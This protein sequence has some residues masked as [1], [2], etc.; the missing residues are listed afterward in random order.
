MAG[1]AA[2][3]SPAPGADDDASGWADAARRRWCRFLVFLAHWRLRAV[4]GWRHCRDAVHAA[5]HRAVGGSWLDRHDGDGS[6][7]L[8]VNSS[9]S[10]TELLPESTDVD[11]PNPRNA[12]AN[13][14]TRRSLPTTPEPR[15]GLPAG[16]GPL[17][18]ERTA[19]GLTIS[20]PALEEAYLSSTHWVDVEA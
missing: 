11:S 1:S 8:A 2:E 9:V 5:W 6:P 12:A 15:R 14:A 20:D 13:R 4:T 16:D 18:V 3:R 17:D 7:E 19:D 10:A